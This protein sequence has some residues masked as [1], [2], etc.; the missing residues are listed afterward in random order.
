M[1]NLAI[2]PLKLSF[3]SEP[4]ITEQ[5]HGWGW[6]GPLVLSSRDTQNS[7]PISDHI[8]MTFEVISKKEMCLVLPG[9]PGSQLCPSVPLQRA[10][11][12][13]STSSSSMGTGS[14]KLGKEHWGNA[15]LPC[16]G[17]WVQLL[18]RQRWWDQEYCSASYPGLGL[19]K[20]ITTWRYS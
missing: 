13:L 3:L 19:F 5:E 15:W 16:H 11:C 9:L 20:D 12:A 7:V 2:S 8:Q 14:N 17:I 10:T 6:Q 18:S 1:K 4:G